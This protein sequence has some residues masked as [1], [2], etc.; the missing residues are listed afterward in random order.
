MRRAA[1]AADAVLGGGAG[2]DHGT[3]QRSDAYEQDEV[4][5]VCRTAGKSDE[6]NHA[7]RGS[8]VGRSGERE[9]GRSGGGVG[10]GRGSRR[11]AGAREAGSRNGRV[12][13]MMIRWKAS[14]CSMMCRMQDARNLKQG[15]ADL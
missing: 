4:A 8:A 13:M 6:G 14:P 5:A 9:A 15:C 7:G 3:G 2:R 1:G 10:M 12:P 11:M